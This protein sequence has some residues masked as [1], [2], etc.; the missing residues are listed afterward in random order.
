MVTFR[1]K[2]LEKGSR[3]F[4]REQVKQGINRSV[5]CICDI[6]RLGNARPSQ[7]E[8]RFYESLASFSIYQVDEKAYVGFYFH[9]RVGITLPQILTSTSSTFGLEIKREFEE[10]WDRGSTVDLDSWLH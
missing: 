1:N 7:V 6:Q 9:G 5:E 8:V 3:P 2:A 4:R 10:L